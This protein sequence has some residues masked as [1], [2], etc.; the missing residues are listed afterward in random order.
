VLVAVA[1]GGVATAAVVVGV[2]SRPEAAPPSATATT[3]HP[4][5]GGGIVTA[6][7]P[8][9]SEGH[10]SF[11]RAIDKVLRDLPL[12]NAAFNA[13][14]TMHL[15]EP[16]VIQLLLSGQRPI[17]ELKE[18]IT[19]LGEKEGAT[20]KAS[21]SME[22]HLT[23]AG[24]TIEPVTPAVQLVSGEGVTEWIWEVEPTQAGKRRLHLTLSAIIDL[25]GKESTYTVRT[26]ER[27]LNI[28]V[29]LRERLTG[30]A[31]DNWQWLWSA[32]LIP[33]G[34]WLLQRRRKDSPPPRS[35]P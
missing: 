4:T 10:G 28:R 11:S 13:P 27:T 9:P 7:P 2:A 34:A 16:T 12:A 32:L 25:R 17:R 33:I 6:P 8:K 24:F 15:N 19:A 18:K 5:T 20:I 3:P 21:D 1:A 26:F 29:T 22:A 14:T 35:N 31:E 30:F 23:G